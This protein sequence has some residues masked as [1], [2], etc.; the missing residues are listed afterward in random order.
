MNS[1]V[2]KKLKLWAEKET[3][4]QRPEVTKRVYKMLKKKYKNK[5]RL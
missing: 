4:G 3:E 5:H 1:R 2:A